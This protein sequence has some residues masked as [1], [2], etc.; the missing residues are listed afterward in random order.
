MVP[1]IFRVEQ[2]YVLARESAKKNVP[3]TRFRGLVCTGPQR[4][5]SIIATFLE[6]ATVLDLFVPLSTTHLSDYRPKEKIFEAGTYLWSFSLFFSPFFGFPWPLEAKLVND[7]TN[8]AYK[9]RYKSNSFTTRGR[10]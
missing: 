7:I 6:V 4:K 2:S 9:A 8:F 5:E 3:D 10:L 1:L